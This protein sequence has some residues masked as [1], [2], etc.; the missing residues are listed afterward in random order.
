MELRTIEQCQEDS[1]MELDRDQ[2]TWKNGFV[3]H[4]Y[5][6]LMETE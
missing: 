5:I 3:R 1:L 6:A 4:G 2:T